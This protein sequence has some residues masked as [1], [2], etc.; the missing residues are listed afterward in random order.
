MTP[1]NLLPWRAE[2][3][4]QL[5]KIFFIS[6]GLAAVSACV[7][8]L[9]GYLFA[10]WQSNV[11]Q[12]DRVSLESKIADLSK[13]TYIVD[14]FFAKAQ[15]IKNQLELINQLE[16]D[17]DSPVKLL[18]ILAESIPQGL[19][20]TQ[21]KY[22]GDTV[23]LQGFSHSSAQVSSFVNNLAQSSVLRDAKVENMKISVNS[24]TAAQEFT[25]SANVRKESP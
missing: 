11:A 24:T 1:I 7:V 17:R 2:R 3:R 14:D 4:E 8:V 25:I 16:R 18:E 9:A 22:E 20:L 12:R 6:L 10:S 21:I 15:A 23:I 5:K 13:Q 19:H